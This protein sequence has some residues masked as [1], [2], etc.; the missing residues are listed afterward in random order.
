MAKTN[1]H[2]NLSERK[3][4]LRVFDVLF[5]LFF[6]FF[7]SNTFAFDYF[8][9]TRD[10]WAWVVVLIIYV[11]V[12]GSI[13]EMYD[14]QKSSKIEKISSSIFFTVSITVLFY[15]LTPFLRQNY[16]IT[17]F[18]FCSSFSPCF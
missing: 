4:L 5:I 10:K 13:F 8:T 7:V 18:K 12:F 2:F 16:P 1:I 9:I 17:V 3:I 15:L 11:S 14:L 6:L